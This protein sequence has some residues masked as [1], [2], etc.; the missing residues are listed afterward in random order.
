MWLLTCDGDLFGH[1]PIWLRPGSGHLLGRTSGRT[2]GGEVVRYINHKSVSR[3]H[4]TIH[5]G[6]VH[7]GDDTRLH[8]RSEIKITDGS[9]IG[10]Y[11]NGE[12]ICQTS[13][14][15][16]KLE[17]TIKLGNYEHEFHLK[18][19][20]VVLTFTGLSKSMKASSDPLEAHRKKLEQ[21]EVKLITEYVS[22]QTTHV[23]GKKRNT[24]PGLQA[25]LQGRWLLAHS[26]VDALAKATA[27]PGRDAG[28]NDRPCPL[29]EDF[30]ANWPREEEHILPAALEPN[31][32]PN[33]FLKPNRHRAE[34]FAN[35]TFIFMSQAQYDLLMPVVTS[36]SGKALLWDVEYEVSDAK[37]LVS[38]VKEVAGA[39]G[40]GDFRLS[41]HTGK[42][43][44]VLV[45][46][47]HKDNEWVREFLTIV[48]STLEQR[49]MEQNQF[50]NAILTVDASELRKPLLRESQ[51][52]AQIAASLNGDSRSTR[53]RAP[54]RSWPTPQPAEPQPAPT[55]TKEPAPPSTQ[56][57]TEQ[58]DMA[59]PPTRKKP[60]RAIT[61]SRFKG[62]GD[63]DPSQFTRPE[64]E[65]PE[66]SQHTPLDQS[67]DV[68]EPS[69]N[70]PSQQNSRKRPAPVDEDDGLEQQRAMMDKMLSGAAAMKK[71]RLQ[72]ENTRCNSQNS[73]P[74]PESAATTKKKAIKK[75]HKEIDVGAELKKKKEEAE[76]AA[77]KEE[78]SNRE[79]RDADIADI[80][81]KVESFS[82][83]QRDLP[84]RR[85]QVEPSGPNDRWDPAWNGRKNFKRFKRKGQ[86]N[87]APRLPRVIVALEE[88]PRK[89]QGIGEEFWLNSSAKSKSQ[90]RSQQ[91]TQTQT[92]TQ[93]PISHENGDDDPA[94]F[95]R[96]IQNSHRE[97]EEAAEMRAVFP[98]EDAGGSA[99]TS[100]S[101][102]G[103]HSTPS[104]TMGT[105]SQRPTAG[106]RA[107]AQQDG[108]AAKRSKATTR[109]APSRV[110]VVDDD[111]DDEVK[112]RRK[113]R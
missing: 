17:Y 91:Q 59:E 48:E 100:G 75:K 29:E 108:P 57:N 14:T 51:T 49:S 65:S 64:S 11:L 53:S 27:S 96:R 104:Q 92:Q 74:E 39:K 56:H 25:L 50:L 105:E 37:D 54:E 16:D 21:S 30:E 26:Y 111:D 83:P 43:G 73:T 97:D 45:R 24:P 33:E 85:A 55:P 90:G 81:A 107:A 80:S 67:M 98:D 87:D 89:R 18:W 6:Q 9:K 35:F 46:L 86:N 76:E 47:D 71:R 82:L 31:P 103:V 23:I 109:P 20:P 3:K 84:P 10:T 60:R 2:E 12:K 95:R 88:V 62:F 41:Q 1:K 40:N 106:K 93:T 22:S 38:Y 13:R 77:R 63:I 42:G 78:E 66:P 32:K 52:Q 101:R 79:A 102:A 28:G 15:L 44:I 7:P 5:V 110:T 68:D 8:T 70:E 112:F 58:A 61:Q 69:Y 113:R 94:R 19:Q 36:G 4:A 72:T 34:L 99:R